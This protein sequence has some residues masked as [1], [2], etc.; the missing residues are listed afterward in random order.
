MAALTGRKLAAKEFRLPDLFE[1]DAPDVVR[2]L[3]IPGVFLR[4]LG[5]QPLHRFR[6]D[7]AVGD[8][9]AKFFLQMLPVPFDERRDRQQIGDGWIADVEPDRSFRESKID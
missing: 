1:D 2:L 6:D 8:T 5:N 3:T 4:S 9:V 7:A